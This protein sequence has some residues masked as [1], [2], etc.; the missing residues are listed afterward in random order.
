MSVLTVATRKTDPPVGMMEP[1][2]VS[3]VLANTRVDIVV[4]LSALSVVD[5]I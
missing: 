5:V 3:L 1:N 2:V 4:P